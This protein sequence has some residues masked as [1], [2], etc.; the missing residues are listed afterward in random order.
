MPDIT[1]PVTLASGAVIARH[2]TGGFKA[3][4]RLVPP[5]WTLRFYHGVWHATRGAFHH[6][7]ATLAEACAMARKEGPR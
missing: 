3:T 2:P 4:G 5:D 1:Y 6:T 7:A